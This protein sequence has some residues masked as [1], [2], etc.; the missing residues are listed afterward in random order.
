[1]DNGGK[2]LAAGPSGSFFKRNCPSLAVYLPKF[3]CIHNPRVALL[4]WL[5]CTLCVILT[6]YYVISND[7]YNILL[8]PDVKVTMCGTPCMPT[9]DTLDAV[10]GPMGKPYCQNNPLT[11]SANGVTYT[12]ITCAGRCGQMPSPAS[13]IFP[14]EAAKIQ[15]DEVFIPTFYHETFYDGADTR[16]NDYFVPGAEQASIVFNHEFYVIPYANSLSFA[17]KP[18]PLKGHSSAFT[19]QGWDEGLLTVLFNQDGS[20]R[21]R[22]APTNPVNVSLHELLQSSY[23]DGVDTS[24]P[25][26][27]DSNYARPDV[28][29]P[30]GGSQDGPPLRLTGAVVSVD[31]FTTDRGVCPFSDTFRKTKKQFKVK[32]VGPVSC[33]SV[34][35]ERIWTSTTENI[36][37]GP[38]SSRQR[39]T[40]GIRVRFRKTGIF[41]FFDEQ[42]FINNLTVFFVWIQIPL[43]MTYWFCI[44]AMGH[45]SYVYSRV[46]HQELCLSDAFQGLSARLLS[47]SAA[48]MDLKD[49]EGG[50]SRKRIKDRFKYYFENNEHIDEDEL[51]R[52]VDFVYKGLKSFA[53]E[54]Q[55]ASDLVTLQEFCN[56]CSSNEPL[57]LNTLVRLFDK[58]RQMGC[59][60]SLF[61]DDMIRGLHSSPDAPAI[62]PVKHDDIRTG[63][64]RD[65]DVKHSR[66]LQAYTEVQSMID[67]LS[68]ISNK[69]RTSAKELDAGPE[70]MAMLGDNEDAQQA[71]LMNFT[72]PP[73]LDQRESV[74]SIAD[75]DEPG[76]RRTE[77]M[78]R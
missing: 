42:A 1:M 74:I 54:S 73:K 16:V 20:E 59:I 53:A 52:F 72:V 69:T 13:C 55:P 33:L 41:S 51:N 56:A 57:R 62:E 38:G 37:T 49:K 47:H 76:R 19:S 46:I 35:T 18:T 23:Y 12:N 68:K 44:T 4:Y 32:W 17:K 71:N 66:L 65:D 21:R 10:M 48:F 5:F 2:V 26:G 11:Y 39:D 75:E 67:T 7:K 30:L 14:Y 3:V 40:F 34:H 60:E 58:D 50:M 70:V 8:E 36:P 24:G 22:W 9:L 27:L 15:G 6:V 61:L 28:G 77:L 29:I 64:A 45:L 25:L 43:V 31:L 78:Q 63:G